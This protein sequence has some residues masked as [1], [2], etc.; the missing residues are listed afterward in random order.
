MR[1]TTPTF[2]VTVVKLSRLCYGFHVVFTVP[3]SRCAWTRDYASLFN[4]SSVGRRR[5]ASVSLISLTKSLTIN[6]RCTRHPRSIIVLYSYALNTA[7]SYLPF[8]P[9]IW[10]FIFRS[11]VF[12]HQDTVGG[13]R[14]VDRAVRKKFLNKIMYATILFT[15]AHCLT[16]LNSHDKSISVCSGTETAVCI[17]SV[18]DHGTA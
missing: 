5:M 3:L 17:F 9:A 18:P 2:P 6:R 12:H 7:S 10:T 15:S 16:W 11:S 1:G 4:V 8:I 13:N 14:A